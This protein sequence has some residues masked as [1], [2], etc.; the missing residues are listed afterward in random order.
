MANWFCNA[1]T[2]YGDR[3]EVLWLLGAVRPDSLRE[4]DEAF[5]FAPF[6]IAVWDRG[7]Q[8]RWGC[9]SDACE[10]TLETLEGA[11]TVARAT[12]DFRTRNGP[13]VGPVGEL[14]ARFPG[15]TFHLAS[16]EFQMA[17]VAE[18]VRVRVPRPGGGGGALRPMA[19]GGAV[20][21]DPPGAG[22]PG[23]RGRGRRGERGGS[24]RNHD[25]IT[26]RPEGWVRLCSQLTGDW[27]AVVPDRE[28]EACLR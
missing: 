18:G 9:Y 20:G 10:S 28:A 12:L 22:S 21:A 27:D 19:P 7:T 14:A 11:S 4:V 23:G 6:G 26:P 16:D 25:W 15:L 17:E 13:A 3:A 24:R 2:V 5:S 8:E 1:L